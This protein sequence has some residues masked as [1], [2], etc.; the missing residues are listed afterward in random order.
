MAEHSEN[1]SAREKEPHQ[2]AGFS[3]GAATEHIVWVFISIWFWFNLWAVSNGQGWVGPY[4]WFGDLWRTTGLPNFPVIDVDSD[5]WATAESSHFPAAALLL[6]AGACGLAVGRPQHWGFR[7]LSYM[8]IAAAVQAHGNLWPVIGSIGV[9]LILAALAMAWCWLSHKFEF[10]RHHENG[11]PDFVLMKFMSDVVL[12][13][14]LPFLGPF[15]VVGLTLSNFTTKPAETPKADLVSSGLGDLKQDV[16]HRG[17]R[18]V[19]N[20][21]LLSAMKILVGLQGARGEEASNLALGAKVRLE[22]PEGAR[23]LPR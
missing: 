2:I 9:L 22:L 6:S 5:F 1:D 21:D 7:T 19:T 16:T 12:H 14:I 13:Y 11:T 23:P 4:S 15:I 20:A 3:L 18:P 8:G 17:T 10:K